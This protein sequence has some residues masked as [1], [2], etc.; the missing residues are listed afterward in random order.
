MST[1][2]APLYQPNCSKG[3]NQWKSKPTANARPDAATGDVPV[4]RTM[5]LAMKTAPDRLP[6]PAERRG[7]ERPIHLRDPK[8]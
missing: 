1:P 3:H 2:V 8:H 5:S 4:S 7:R 6:Q